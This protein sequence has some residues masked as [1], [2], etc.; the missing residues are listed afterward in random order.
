MDKYINW[1]KKKMKGLFE[2]NINDNILPKDIR[3]KT[4]N[5]ECPFWLI[6]TSFWIFIFLSSILSLMVVSLY[7]KKK[8]RKKDN[9]S[10]TNIIMNQTGLFK[11]YYN[12]D[13]ISQNTQLINEDFNSDNMITD[14]IIN[15]FLNERK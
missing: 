7:P 3:T 10:P 12:I 4:K 9:I 14:M 1:Y 2:N 11:C 13:D 15:F 8:E 5:K 6:V